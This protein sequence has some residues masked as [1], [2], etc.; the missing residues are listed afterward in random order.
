MDYRTFSV[1]TD[2]IARNCTQGYTRTVREPT[3]KVDSGR[4][5]PGRTGELNLQQWYASLMLYQLSYILT[6]SQ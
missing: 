1:R 5:I 2:V 4:K 3:L 6:P